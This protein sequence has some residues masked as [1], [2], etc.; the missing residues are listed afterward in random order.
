[1][2][3]LVAALGVLFAGCAIHVLALTTNEG[4]SS[5][6]QNVLFE[7][8]FAISVS[9]LNSRAHLQNVEILLSMHFSGQKKFVLM[10]DRRNS[11]VIIEAVEDDETHSTTLAANKLSVENGINNGLVLL[12]RQHVD[13]LQAD[14]YADC[15]FQGTMQLETA[16]RDMATGSQTL[17]MLAYT[18]KRYRYKVYKS[19]DVNYVLAKEGCFFDSPVNDQAIQPPPGNNEI[20]KK[21]R[22]DIEILHGLDDK[23]CITDQ[24][25]LKT[26]NELI[27]VTGKLR[28]EILRNNLEL[29][30]LR[31]MIDR[32]ARCYETKII[33]PEPPK[34]TCTVNSPCFPGARCR[35]TANGPQCLSCPA[36]YIGDGYRCR[37][38][39]TC[40][41]RP[42]FQGVTCRD[43]RNGFRC[44]S[45]PPGYVGNGEHCVRRRVGCETNP[46][47]PQVLCHS[48]DYSPYYRC[49][50]C[51]SGFTGNGTTCYDL[52][53]CDLV[54][55]CDPRASCYNLSP[56]YK[57]GPCPPGFI[58][59]EVIGVGM[60][61][62]RQRHV[63][64]D[65]DECADGNNGGCVPYS[66]CINTPGSFHC[67]E[68]KRGTS[69][70]Q[71][72]GCKLNP[73]V[74][75][76]LN[77]CHTKA[78]CRHFGG[79]RYEC[80]CNVGWAGN[81][82]HCNPDT[83]ADSYPDKEIPNCT[84]PRCKADNCPNH[85]NSGQED[86]DGDG[87]GDA[88]DPDA[89]RD[90]IP[91]H[92]DNCPLVYNPDQADR[93]GD[94]RGDTCDNCPTVPNFDQ[95]DTDGDGV[96]DACSDDMDNDGIK[97]KD[98]NCPTVPN[99]DQRDTDGDGVGDACDNCPTVPNPGQEDKDNDG[100]GDVC[101]DNV[102][103]DDDGAPDSLD[104]CPTIPNAEQTD[105]DGDG[106][107]DAC[108]PD[109]DNDK[110]P[111]KVDNCPYFYNPNQEDYN[112]N[113]IGDL[114][115]D[116]NDNDTIPNIHDV[117]PNN[118]QIWTVDFRKYMTVNLDP[119]GTSQKDPVWVVLNKGAEILQ[120]LNSDPGMA[121]GF[122]RFD[123]LDYEGTF[124][125]DDADEDDDFVGFVF[126]YQDSGKF[127]VFT[128]K[129]L[130]QTYWQAAPFRAVA[131]PGMI[132]RLVDS[133]TGPG[134][135]LRNS[136]WHNESVPTET[137]I[138]WR[139]PKK[140]GWQ[141]RIPYR[142]L[143]IHRP[144]IGLIRIWIYEGSKLV[145][146]SGNIFDTYLKG[147]RI[148]VYCFSQEMIIWSNLNHR[149]NDQVPPFVYHEL[150]PNLKALVD[151]DL[152]TTSFSGA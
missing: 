20:P 115:E 49:G 19:F 44:E 8:E 126:G 29:A 13:G 140:L 110:V 21:I 3:R 93:D 105:T 12:I 5:S 54:Q 22:G 120:T 129:K 35:D 151:I 97:N 74:C 102:D 122:E 17:A 23:I 150:P 127:Y 149:C 55:P 116:D 113:G 80:K 70:N 14:L 119:R 69:G 123:G 38:G 135:K 56:G 117:C 66:E 76:D 78:S 77:I 67:G 96:G 147:G 48:T 64:E 83:D 24:V 57:C 104:N 148:G 11:R 87:K 95:K 18:Q 7:D 2:G 62:D 111:N 99:P 72:V 121:I 40:A 36:G 133:A 89:D 60:D 94:N 134:V 9:H 81:G 6:L 145:T 146:D 125:V 52:D 101:D 73:G 109:I 136:L 88:C 128:W 82:Y 31:Q 65:I 27:S 26:F 114:C 142:W 51:P 33:V 42:C 30:Q 138:L 141:P 37:P 124:Y 143:L 79:G 132:L 32:C 43:T 59:N 108:D 71:T 68:C 84:D 86:A 47:H 50:Q 100:I 85:P 118:S 137:R 25:L 103:K 41:D 53:E 45:C 144:K 16:L 98:D 28:E 106:L 139:D 112:R 1:M 15:V 4:L 107:G 152:S 63:C 90:G 130:Q 34:V 131:E 10:L 92:P 61:R 39:R 58:G 46:C 75:P 91:N